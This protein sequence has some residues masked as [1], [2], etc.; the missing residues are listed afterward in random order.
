MV[1]DIPLRRCVLLQVKLSS[2]PA[3]VGFFWARA[4]GEGDQMWAP[5]P[6][7]LLIYV[8]P[9]AGLHDAVSLSSWTSVKMP[10]RPM[11]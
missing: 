6:R 11:A 5:L 1:V 4:Q 9:T 7:S 3:S 8:K 2:C 10:D